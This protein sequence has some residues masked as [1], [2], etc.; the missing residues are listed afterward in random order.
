MTHILMPVLLKQKNKK[1]RT[2]LLPREYT[3]IK[4]HIIPKYHMDTLLFARSYI[5]M[6]QTN[7]YNK[8][9]FTILTQTHIKVTKLMYITHSSTLPSSYKYFPPNNFFFFSLLQAFLLSPFRPS[10]LSDSHSC[11]CI[12]HHILA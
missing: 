4:T 5:I 10:T 8:T 2:L 11:P 6:Y 12:S 3:K 7:H 1:N 9:V